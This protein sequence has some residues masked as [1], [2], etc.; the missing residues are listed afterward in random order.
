MDSMVKQIATVEGMKCDGC[1][2]TV[3]TKFNELSGVSKVEVDLDSNTAVLDAESNLTADDL[4]SA[5]E[6][7]PYEVNEVK[8]A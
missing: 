6:D 7:T 4:G 5:L 1:A 2:N 8:N 3:Q